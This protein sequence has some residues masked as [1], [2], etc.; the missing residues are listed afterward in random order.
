[1][2]LQRG[3]QLEIHIHYQTGKYAGK[4]MTHLA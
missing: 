2:N 1:M 4:M 3:L